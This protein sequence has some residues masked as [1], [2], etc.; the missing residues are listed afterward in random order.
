MGKIRDRLTAVL[1]W[2]EPLL[3]YFDLRKAILTG[4][5]TAGMAGWT[6]LSHLSWPSIAVLTLT[7]LVHVSYLLLLPA[8]IKLIHVGVKARPNYS[9]WR[10]RQRFYLSE[11]GCLLADVVPV[12][13]ASAMDADSF[14]WYGLL[15]EA[16]KTGEIQHIKS[17][18]DQNNKDGFNPAE[19]TEITVEQFKAF[20]EKRDRRPEFLS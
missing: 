3:D 8:F 7:T 18:Y 1:P 11:A 2:A 4:V 17:N 9:I 10:H 13:P 6:Y 14:A 19:N 16:I 15:L 5:V 12:Y 20:C